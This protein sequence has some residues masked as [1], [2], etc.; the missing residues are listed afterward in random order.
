MLCKTVVARKV[1]FH[2]WKARTQ[3]S[4]SALYRID[5]LG[6][7]GAAVDACLMVC[8]LTPGARSIECQVFDDIRGKTR[9]STFALRANRLIADL[10]ALEA[11]G[12]LFGT[13]SR[14]WRSGV[15]HDCARVMEVRPTSDEGMYVNGLGEVVRLEGQ[16]LYPMM[17]SSELARRTTPS[18]MM[19][20]TQRSKKT[21]AVLRIV[22]RLLGDTWRLMRKPRLPLKFDL[23]KPASLFGLWYW[24]IQLHAMEGGDFRLLQETGV[25]PS[26]SERR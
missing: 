25:C 24:R 4:E 7:F 10:D 11:Y 9:Q 18:R 19:L 20:V 14:K 1:L 23:Q 15:K 6:H 17:K 22:R 3:I 21:Q 5:A 2:A 26:W 13:S 8:V 12:H 16:F